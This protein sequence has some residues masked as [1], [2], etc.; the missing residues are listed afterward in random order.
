MKH[1]ET[2][3]QRDGPPSTLRAVIFDLDDTLVVS[4]VNFGKFKTLVI[5]R[6]ASWGDQRELYSP[7]E[8]IVRIVNRC[9]A[10]M[11]DQGTSEPETRSRLAELD[12]IMDEVELEHVDETQGIEGARE[13]LDFLKGQG[14]KVGVLTRGCQEYALRA[15]RK[16]GLLHLVDACECRNSDVK[17]KPN[18]ESYQRLASTLGVDL[19]E[20]IFVGDHAI[21]VQCAANAGVPFIG[22]L[23]GDVPRDEL[24]DAG[25]VMVFRD[26]KEMLEWLR[27]RA[28]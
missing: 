26:A 11:R 24:I 7:S 3:W 21:D 25:S 16:T 13:L 4:T 2:D 28:K 18:P 22:V 20:T 1:K 6:I 8:T 23:T 14:M 9:E 17:P 27:S 5:D 10:R 19:D 12:R 15:M